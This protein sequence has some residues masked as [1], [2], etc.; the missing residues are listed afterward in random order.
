M[1]LAVPSV[2]VALVALVAL[3]GCPTPN[4]PD[5]ECIAAGGVCFRADDPQGCY[6]PISAPCAS[7]PIAYAC[8]TAAY[9]G[10]ITRDGGLIDADTGAPPPDAAVDASVADAHHKDALSD[11]E[12]H[13]DGPET[14][15]EASTDAKHDAPTVSMDSGHTPDAMHDST[16]SHTPDSSSDH[17]AEHDAH[18]EAH[19]DSGSHDDAATDAPHG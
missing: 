17:D 12:E 11:A 9:G 7:T 13:K 1:R 2:V 8:C 10:N 4:P 5:A 15:S 6:L 18:E 14:S 19:A 16:M 3:A